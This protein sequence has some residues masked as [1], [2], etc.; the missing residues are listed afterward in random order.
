M[1]GRRQK[2]NVNV[3]VVQDECMNLETFTLIFFSQPVNLFRYLTIT[4][5]LNLGRDL[6]VIKTAPRP[7]NTNC[8][9]TIHEYH[10]FNSKQASYC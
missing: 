9:E 7:F 10:I 8:T 5:N 6:L 3:G 2:R 4:K 1:S